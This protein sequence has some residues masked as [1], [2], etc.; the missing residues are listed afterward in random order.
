[1]SLS[2]NIYQESYLNTLQNSTL[3]YAK[4]DLRSNDIA[5]WAHSNFRIR[6]IEASTPSAGKEIFQLTGLTQ[7]TSPTLALQEGKNTIYVSGVPAVRQWFDLVISY[8]KEA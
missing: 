1:M 5:N 4:S 8:T 3:F 7:I 2:L 6:T